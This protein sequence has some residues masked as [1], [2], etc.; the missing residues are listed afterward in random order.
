MTSP[1]IVLLIAA[2]AT[3]NLF[4]AAPRLDTPIVG[5]DH[6]VQLTVQGDVGAEYSIEWSVDLAHWNLVSTGVAVNGAL[7]VHHNAAAYSTI[8]YRAKT[9]ASAQSLRIYPEYLALNV[10]DESGL[11]ALQSAES[12]QWSSSDPAIATVDTNGVVKAVAKGNATISVSSSGKTVSSS[13]VVYSPSGANP[14]VTSAALIARAF[15]RNEITAEQELIYRTYA[16]FG[17]SRLPAQFRG[18]PS[19][20][21]NDLFLSEIRNRINTLSPSAQQI[22]RPFLLPPIYAESWF[23]QQ[24][25]LPAATAQNIDGG[26]GGTV[27]CSATIA[28]QLYTR[29]ATAHFN[30]VTLTLGD[31]LYDRSTAR[32][33][34]MAT[35]IAEQVY[36]AETTLLGRFPLPDTGEGCNGGDG[37]LDIYV[38][39]IADANL[40][41]QAV[42]YREACAKTPSYMIL[43]RS[44]AN[45]LRASLLSPAEGTPTVRAVLAHEFMHVLQFAM[46]RPNDCNDSK[47]LDEATAQWAIDYV[48]SSFNHEDGFIKTSATRKRSGTYFSEYLVTDHTASIENTGP[49]GNPKA[50]GYADYIFFQFLARKYSPDVIKQ[51]FDANAGGN[52]SVESIAAALSSRGG[53]KNVWPEFATTLWNDTSGAFL[54]FWKTQD[55]YDV[56]LQYVFSPPASEFRGRPGPDLKTIEVDQKGEPKAKFILLKNAARFEGGYAIEPRSFY[57]EHLKFTD[58]TVHSVL[59]FNPIAVMPSREFI[60]VQAWTKIDGQ[61]SGPHD[62]TGDTHKQFCRDKKD[63]RLEELLLLVSNSEANRGSEQPFELPDNLPLHVSTSNVGCWQWEGNSST[64]FT[65]SDGTVIK[66]AAAQV[67]YEVTISLAT[68]MHFEATRGTASA[69]QVTPL[70]DCTITGTAPQTAITKRPI[71]DGTLIYNLDLDLGLGEPVNRDVLALYGSTTISTTTTFVCPEFNQTTV[72]DQ[73]WPWLPGIMPA[74]VAVSADGQTIE[75]Q[76]TTPHPGGLGNQTATFKFTAKRE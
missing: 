17:D 69:S 42:P 45:L 28:P 33:A 72:A 21:E 22:L 48:D 52:R 14:D 75:G 12:R 6:N 60:K 57:Y 31:P 53:F 40:H 54:D 8:F 44:S 50:N 5:A 62:W 26:A 51:I 49:G 55:Q 16:T 15:A 41:G 11:I 3:L 2:T 59:F 36:T 1:H 76:I 38:T 30:I 39:S 34:E 29:R 13:V 25:G 71:P 19:P 18:A 47:W 27:N 63:E 70:G 65:G 56:G 67:L 68:R 66:T 9:S 37:A 73:S 32:I 23:A 74:A 10:G 64:D 61:W 24:L 20:I 7:T 4:A 35:T 46:D 43:N 58:E